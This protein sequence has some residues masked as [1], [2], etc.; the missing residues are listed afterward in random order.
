MSVRSIFCLVLFWC[1]T[2]ATAVSAQ[3][4]VYYGKAATAGESHA[5]GL[6]DVVRAQ[7]EYNLLTSEAAINAEEVRSREL[8]NRLKSTQTFFEM[9][10]INHEERFGD[11][12]ERK[13]RNE[14]QRLFR[15]GEGKPTRLSA[16]ELDPVTG[17]V[18][19]PMPLR[20]PDYE[21][22]RTELDPLF[23]ER[24]YA[25]GGIGY[26]SYE[27]IQALCNAFLKQLKANIRK[28]DSSDYVSAKDF[29]E[30]MAHE[31]QFST[32]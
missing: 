26:E 9:R 11:Y 31:V 17:K 29:V 18:Y 12:P 10:R 19:W 14:Q 1:V 5:R 22:Y 16:K 13:A 28:M 25:S 6:A 15:Y 4:Y 32:S 8:D 20:A 7:G 3:E 21:A 30:R 23:V 27:R 2:G 24:A